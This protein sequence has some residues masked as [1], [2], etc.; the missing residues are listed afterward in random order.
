[1]NSK[2][3]F[4]KW[5]YFYVEG[6]FKNT[7]NTSRYGRALKGQRKRLTE[8]NLWSFHAYNSQPLHGILMFN[9]IYS[10]ARF[11]STRVFNRS[12]PDS[13]VAREQ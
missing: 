10:Q 12:L 4:V 5:K 1:M 11:V 13:V 2:K 8:R 9:S 7:V 6:A 3:L